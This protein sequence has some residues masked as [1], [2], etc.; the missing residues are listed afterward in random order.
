MQVVGV[1]Y[2]FFI[3]GVGLQVLT[4]RSPTLQMAGTLKMV[5]KFLTNAGSEAVGLTMLGKTAEI[6]IHK[7]LLLA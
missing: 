7:V 1:F 3:S 4:R 2:S 6:C 5:E